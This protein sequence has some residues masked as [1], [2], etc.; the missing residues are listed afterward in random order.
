VLPVA[1]SMQAGLP[2]AAAD[3]LVS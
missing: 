1:G 2:A 3:G